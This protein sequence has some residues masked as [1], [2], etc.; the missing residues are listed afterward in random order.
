MNRLRFFKKHPVNK[1]PRW[2]GGVG[3]DG[4]DLTQED[5]EMDLRDLII[6]SRNKAFY[7]SYEDMRSQSTNPNVLKIIF[8][9]DGL[10]R[11]RLFLVSA[12][13]YEN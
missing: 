4:I 11:S 7:K 3:D 2:S 10:L 5:E 1:D 8:L 9:F 12:A 13:R 6:N